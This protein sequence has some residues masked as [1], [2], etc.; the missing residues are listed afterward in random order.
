MTRTRLLATTAAIATIAAAC[1]DISN[2]SQDLSLNSAFNSALLGFD[3]VQ[4]TF[5]GGEINLTS[6]WSPGGGRGPGGGAGSGG[7]C[8]G[9][10]GGLFRGDLGLG[11]GLGRF[12]DG[13][14]SDE[15]VFQQAGGRVVCPA[16]TRNGLTINRSAAYTNASGAVQSAFDSVTTNAINVRVQV[17]GTLTH[18]N[19]NTTA[20]QHASDRTVRG[21]VASSTTRTVNGTSAGTETTNGTNDQG[22]FVAQRVMG[23]TTTNVVVPK[24]AGTTPTYPTS[25]TI[26]RSMRATVTYTGQAAQTSSRRELVT[27]NGTSTATVVITRDGV[28]SNCTL[29]LPHG[30]LSCQ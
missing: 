9:G 12:G 20:V 25:G 18:R 23:D 8:G 22:T 6:A 5:V 16:V 15:C 11:F 24:Q 21:L 10:A 14:L 28:T 13:G 26:V 1:A 3:N 29:P 2:P 4:S 19:G 27:F 17:S 30:R 7:M